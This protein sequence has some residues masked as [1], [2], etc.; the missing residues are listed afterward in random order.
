MLAKSVSKPFSGK[1]WIFEIKWDGFRAIAYIDD[2]FTIQSRNAKE[3][4]HFFPELEELRRLSKNVVVDDEIITMKQGKVDFHSLQER[5]HVI[6]A[7]EIERL[8]TKSPVTFVIF[9]ILEKDGEA[10]VDLPLIERK[11]ILKES[12]KE[13]SHVILNDYIEEKGEQFYN[14]VLQQDLEGMVAKL[15][16]SH[17]E[18][19]LRTG[20]W[21]KVKN[22][23]SCDCAIFGY[24][25]GT[26][27]RESTFG[28]L[29]VGLYDPEGKPIYIAHV[30]TGFTQQLLD[31]LMADFKKLKTTPAP[32]IARDVEDIT[33]VE[34]KLVCEVIYQVVTK[35]CKLRMPR[36]H[37][38]RSDKEP[39]ECTIDQIE[40][41]GKCFLP[42]TRNLN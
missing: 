2:F 4:K 18:E 15:K 30:G 31:S 28:A 11:A 42:N 9:D 22:I 6:S 12:V 24:S 10:L 19:G 8:R 33:W 27:A 32:F 39:S 13:S 20:S 26:G 16:D 21:L 38:L 34:P 1:D 36:L 37:T 23:K 7:R 5:G 25:K 41:K 29:V 35:D 14:A 3:L 17:Y 40:G